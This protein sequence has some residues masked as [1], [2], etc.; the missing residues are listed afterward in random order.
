MK[1]LAP[2]APNEL[3]PALRGVGRSQ[4]VAIL[5]TSAAPWKGVP[6]NVIFE[7]T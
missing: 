6:S 3:I 2:P 1:A 4:L 7:L 5:P